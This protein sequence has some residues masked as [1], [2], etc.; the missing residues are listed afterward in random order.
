[1]WFLEQRKIN[2]RSR[3]ARD[4]IEIDM[5]EKQVSVILTSFNKPFFVEK[6]IKSVLNQTYDDIHLIIADDNSPN[7]DVD[8]V[9]RNCLQ[10]ND[11]SKKVT[12]FTSNIE[13]KDRLKTARY[14]TQI[15][16]AVRNFSNSK[17]VCYLADD[18]FYYPEMIEKMVS[19]TEKTNHKVVFCAQHILDEDG[20]V[21]GG[22][23]DGRGVRFF[24]HPLDRG[25]DKLDHNQVMTTREVFDKVGG[26]DDWHGAWSG[27]DA[28]FFDRIEKV[29]KEKFYPID[30]STPLQAKV[31]RTNS[32]QWNVVNNINPDG[33][34][35]EVGNG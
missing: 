3:E 11:T 21:D 7:K 25:A 32:V 22:G 8:K 2:E 13:E 12:Y 30:V 10:Q 20:N 35:K 34:L 31:Y 9:I 1:M 18:D 28:Y 24:N 4:S 33:S 26:W 29:A 6:A 15:N 14:A 19:F 16:T 17:Y 23:I 27:A 5:H